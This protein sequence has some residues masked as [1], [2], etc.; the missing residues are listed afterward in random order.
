MNAAAIVCSTIA[1]HS[2]L[3][4][5]S[6]CALQ[7][8][9]GTANSPNAAVTHSGCLATSDVADDRVVSV[10]ALQ[11]DDLHRV[12]LLEPCHLE[13][14]RVA[15]A[16][17]HLRPRV[18]VEATGL[19]DSPARSLQP[20]EIAVKTSAGASHGSVVRRSP[21][22][23]RRGARHDRRRVC[24]TRRR[25]SAAPQRSVSWPS[26]SRRPGRRCTSRIRTSCQTATSSTSSPRRRR[27][28]STCAS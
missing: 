22:A 3:T 23:G 11:L 25:P 24:C 14:R 27:A 9:D 7:R 19:D 12:R 20:S 13:R 26:P 2:S 28:A 16:L 15:V 1:A 4:K 6:Q 8:R 5:W 21:H 17:V 18:S 10:D